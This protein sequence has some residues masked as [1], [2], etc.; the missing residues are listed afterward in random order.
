VFTGR[1]G[2]L[3]AVAYFMKRRDV[4]SWIEDGSLLI[5]VSVFVA[6][7]TWFMDQA[8]LIPALLYGLYCAR[9]RN[10][11]AILALMSAMIE[12]EILGGVPLLTSVF[13]LWTAPA[14]LVWYLFATSTSH[15]IQVRNLASVS[16]GDL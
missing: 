15:T 9:S 6:P 11:V 3:W 14:F 13:Y 16:S 1:T 2:C 10:L 8:I 4:W 7:Y 5:L 12:I